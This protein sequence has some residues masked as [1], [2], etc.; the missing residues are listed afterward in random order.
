MNILRPLLPALFGFRFSTVPATKGG[1]SV[2]VAATPAKFGVSDFAYKVSE[3]DFNMKRSMKKAAVNKWA[4]QSDLSRVKTQQVIRENQDVI[5]SSAVVDIRKG[6][7]ISLPKSDTYHII[8][9]IDFQNYVV[10]VLY[11]GDSLTVTTDQV[12]YGNYV[13]LNMRIRILPKDKGGLA[14]TLKLQKMA[15]IKAKSAVPYKSPDIVIDQ[16]KMEQIR[17]ALIKD[18]QA[19]ALPDTSASIGTPLSTRPQDHLYATAYGWGGLPV[20]HAVYLPIANQTEVVGGKC[21]PSSVTFKPPAI[22]EQRGGFWSITTYDKEGWLAKDE[23]AISNTQATANA[24]GTY[25]IRFNS[26]DKPN[27]LE[28]TAPFAALLRFYVPAS[29]ESALSFIRKDSKK[30]IIR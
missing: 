27:N 4:H 3:T 16:K 28:T 20:E 23:A 18:V 15:K 14:K 13:Y 30:M 8:E 17:A 12:T 6:A 29:R 7:T 11:P 10:D 9:I 19:G 25:T 24:N 1:K 5:Y 21:K 2:A 22:D 26:P